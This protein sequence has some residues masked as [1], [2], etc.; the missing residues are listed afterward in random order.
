MLSQVPTAPKNIDESRRQWLVL[1]SREV[2]VHPVVHG[3]ASRWDEAAPARAKRQAADRVAALGA[4]RGIQEHARYSD[5][6]NFGTSLRGPLFAY[7]GSVGG[8]AHM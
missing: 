5:P 3:F 1:Q 2:H 8:T 6:P 7:E 4:V